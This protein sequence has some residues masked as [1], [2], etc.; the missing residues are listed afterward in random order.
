MT[1]P[2]PHHAVLALLV[3]VAAALICA[4]LIVLLR[5]WLQRYALARPN[6]RSSHVTPTPQGGGIA[7]MFAT[8]IAAALAGLLGLPAPAD[9]VA[10]VMAASLCL[11]AVGMIDDLK[12]IPVWPRLALQLA[13]VVLV[14]AAL[15]SQLRIFEAVPIALERAL[16]ILGMLW[17]INLVNFM[18]GLDWMTVAEMLPV[19]IALAA[20]ALFGEAPSEVLPIALAL[21]GALLGFA[22]FNRPV[23]RL[24]LGDVG[25]LPIGLIIGWCLIE[26]ASRQHVAAALLLPLY[27]LVDATITLFRRLA[28]REPFWIAHRSHY[29]QRATDHGFSVRQV[30]TEVFL[31]NLLLAALAIASIAARSTAVDLALLALGALGVMAVLVRFSRPRAG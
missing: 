1:T 26:L 17:F 5:P 12:P 3:P 18:D 6:A 11:A 13:A 19:T 30:V 15:P 2:A 31:L 9:A 20:F 24:F 27:Y 8:A 16:L 14:F 29:Y 7:V 21:A 4:G 25:S 10:I 28:R 22:P 23:A